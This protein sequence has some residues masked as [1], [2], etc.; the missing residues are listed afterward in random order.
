MASTNRVALPK[1]VEPYKHHISS[2]KAEP[3]VL[4]YRLESE[5]NLAFTNSIVFSTA[6]Q[7]EAQV[8]LIQ[9]MVKAGVL[10]LVND[11]SDK[12][13]FAS[14]WVGPTRIEYGNN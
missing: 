10:P 3:E 1:E 2:G 5:P 6:L 4:L 12:L 14:K 13:K 7:V 11:E 8:D 9:R